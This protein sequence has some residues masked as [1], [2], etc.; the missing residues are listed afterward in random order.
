MDPP[1]NPMNIQDQRLWNNHVVD[2]MVCKV[3][4]GRLIQKPIDH[5]D[6]VLCPADPTHKGFISQTKATAIESQQRLDAVEVLQNYP[7]FNPQPLQ[8]TSQESIDA[9]YP[10]SHPLNEV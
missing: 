1:G 5:Q 6:V 8:E 4:F 2:T 7:Q 3:C 10:S 9:L